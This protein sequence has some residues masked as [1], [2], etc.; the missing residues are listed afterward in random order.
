MGGELIN[1]EKQEMIVTESL[2]ACVFV[3]RTG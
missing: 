2:A 3:G 1:L